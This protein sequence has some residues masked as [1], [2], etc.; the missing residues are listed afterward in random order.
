MVDANLDAFPGH[1][2]AEPDKEALKELMVRIRDNPEEGR[3]KGKNA[4]RDILE[5]WSHEKVALGIRKELERIARF[6]GKMPTVE[7]EER[8]NDGKVPKTESAVRP[9][10]E[11]I[12]A[13]AKG[14]SV[15]AAA[16]AEEDVDAE[17]GQGGQN[18]RGQHHDEL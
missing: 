13:A 7:D 6:G 8:I 15:A 9:A 1:R 10:E 18:D 17:R 4:R 16:A 3:K 5:K 12:E 11:E 14:A 2:W